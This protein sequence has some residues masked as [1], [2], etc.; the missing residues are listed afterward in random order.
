MVSEI[1][2]G[3]FRDVKFVGCKIEDNFCYGMLISKEQQDHKGGLHKLKKHGSSSTST[4]LRIELQRN[5]VA[6]NKHSG[7]VIECAM[8]ETDLVLKRNTF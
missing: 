8:N 2:E 6:S 3:G 4:Q 1:Q 7:L 5:I